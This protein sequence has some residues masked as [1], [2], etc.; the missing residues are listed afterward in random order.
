MSLASNLMTYDKHPTRGRFRGST[1]HL[2]T[3]YT[4]SVKYINIY[5]FNFKNVDDL[6]FFFAYSST[7]SALFY[8]YIYKLEEKINQLAKKRKKVI[9][10]FFQVHVTIVNVGHP[11]PPPPTQKNIVPKALQ[12]RNTR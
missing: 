2:I 10:L 3:F 6:N 1:P 11:K 5:N 8:C 12:H 7:F 9:K 4:C